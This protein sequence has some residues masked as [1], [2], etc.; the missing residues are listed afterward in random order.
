MIAKLITHGADREECISRMKRAL[1]EYVIM[2]V[3]NTIQLHQ[4]ILKENNFVSG[5][6]NINFMNDIR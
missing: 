3:D 6:Y 2:G 1:E 4:D 5:K